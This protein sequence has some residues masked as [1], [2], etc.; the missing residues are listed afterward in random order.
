MDTLL[1]SVK[2]NERNKGPIALREN[3]VDELSKMAEDIYTAKD[4]RPQV[5]QHSDA[6]NCTWASF[7]S[8][9]SHIHGNQFKYKVARMREFIIETHIARYPEE[10]WTE[11]IQAAKAGIEKALKTAAD[12]NIRQALERAQTKLKEIKT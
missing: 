6:I 7:E 3:M 11:T 2:E 5:A 4:S 1:E 12:E 10:C 8:F 9:L